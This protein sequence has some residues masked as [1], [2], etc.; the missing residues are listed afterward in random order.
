MRATAWSTASDSEQPPLALSVISD[1]VSCVKDVKMDGRM[2]LRLDDKDLESMGVNE[3]WREALLLAS[4]NL[5]QNVIKGRIWGISDSPPSGFSSPSLPSHPFSSALYNS[6]TSSVDLT[7]SDTEADRPRRRRGLVRGMV[8]SLERSGSFSSESSFDGDGFDRAEV[9]E[10]W[11]IEEGPVDEEAV[12]SSSPEDSVPL[13][14]PMI[15]TLEEEPSVEALLASESNDLDRT[16]T[17][18]ARAWEEMDLAPGITVKRIEPNDGTLLDLGIKGTIIGLGHGK[19]RTNSR[20]GKDKVERRVV[21]AIFTPSPIEQV[22]QEPIPV[23]EDS[24]ADYQHGIQRISPFIPEEAS[25]ESHVRILALE[26]ELVET[27]SLVEAFRTRLEAVERKLLESEETHA[28]REE[29]HRLSAI[30]SSMTQKEIPQVRPE[31]Q[32]S[33][34]VD[35]LESDPLTSFAQPVLSVLRATLVKQFTP[36][37]AGH[38]SEPIHHRK[39]DDDGSPAGP[40]E[41]STLSDLPSYVFLVGIG[42]CAVVLQVMLKKMAGRSAGLNWRN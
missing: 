37:R 40:D 23:V 10:R 25:E 41:P 42:V 26:E 2:F 34:T 39:Q 21:T 5:R 6:S 32:P 1:I 13:A 8:E 24:F 31:E 27:R 9:I 11:T 38:A 15:S 16:E 7:Q 33:T 17:W 22:N 35:I 30:T 19:E 12:R 29:I 4:R 14:S 20:R 18:G 36:S 3:E 28:E